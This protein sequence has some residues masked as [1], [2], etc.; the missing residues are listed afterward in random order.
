MK[1]TPSISQHAAEAGAALRRYVRIMLALFRREEEERRAAPGE[2]IMNLLEPIFMIVT[3]S[4]AWWFLNRNSN[5][6]LGGSPVLFFG[7]G[8]YAKFFLIYISRRMGR[9]VESAGRRFPI[10]Q[11]LDHILVHMIL[12][13]ID[14]AILGFLLFG[15]IY[16][17]FTTQAFPANFGPLLQGLLAIAALGF[18]WGVLNITMRQIWW[19]WDYFFPGFNRVLILFSGIFFLPDFLAPSAR[20]IMSF[21][22]MVH[23]IILFR[24]GFYPQYKSLVLD[25]TYLAYCVIFAIV[26]GLVMERVTR[27]NEK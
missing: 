13:I 9:S 4:L 15:V 3:I 2:A 23:A 27:R 24:Q 12:R 7:S 20:Y 16:F 6:P 17:F 19:M 10:E 18:G 25:T 26:G 14:Y 22:P 1:D 11:R 8:L 21:N 5:S